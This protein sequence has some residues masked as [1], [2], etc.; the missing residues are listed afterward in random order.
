MIIIKE[1]LIGK[2]EVKEDLNLINMINKNM[3]MK[4]IEKG[5]EIEEVKEIN[6]LY[7]QLILIKLEVKVQLIKHYNYLQSSINFSL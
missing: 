4:E 2:K 5:I 1:H 6:Y 3:D 7:L